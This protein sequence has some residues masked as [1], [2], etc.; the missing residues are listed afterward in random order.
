MPSKSTQS[1]RTLHLKN[2]NFQGYEMLRRITFSLAILVKWTPKIFKNALFDAKLQVIQISHLS[3]IIISPSRR[4]TKKMMMRPIAI[5]SKNHECTHV[6]A[7]L[8]LAVAVRCCMAWGALCRILEPRVFLTYYYS[9]T[10]P[11]YFLSVKVAS[12]ARKVLQSAC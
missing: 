4:H 2:F 7:G 1:L 8:M 3:G 9:T 6:V 5:S 10:M 12:Y 11:G